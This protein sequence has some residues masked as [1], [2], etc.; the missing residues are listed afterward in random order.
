MSSELRIDIN[1]AVDV[2]RHDL[3]LEQDAVRFFS[4]FG[5]DL[6][7]LSI[8]SPALGADISDTTW[9]LHEKTKRT[10]SPYGYGQGLRARILG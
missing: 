9:Y 10:L 2:V 6:L 4:N 8:D 3:G 1:Q 7:E 5:N